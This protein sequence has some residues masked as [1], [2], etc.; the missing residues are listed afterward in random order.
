MQSSSQE[1]EQLRASSLDHH[2]SLLPKTE[3]LS[4]APSHVA[5][6]SPV[7]HE[8]TPYR[9]SSPGWSLI[10]WKF[11]I[12]SWIGSLCFFIAILVVLNVL[13]GRPLPDL[14]Y[15]ITPNAIIGLL[16]TFGQALLLMPVSSALGQMKWLQALEKRPMDNFETLDKASRGPLGSTKLIVGRKSGLWTYTTI[17]LHTDAAYVPIAQ[18]MNGTGWAPIGDTGVIEDG[19]D[20]ELL[21]APYLAFFNPLHTNFTAASIARCGSNNCT[22]DSYQT[23][24]LRS[25]CHDLSSSLNMTKVYMAPYDGDPFT[26]NTD[27]YTLPNGFGLT[28]AQPRPLENQVFYNILNGMVNVTTSFSAT[29]LSTVSPVWGSIAFPHNGSA[30]MSVFVVGPS[31]GTI[32]I[33]PD[34]NYSKPMNGSMFAPPVA[35]ECLLQFC[36]RNMRAEVMN[37]TIYETELFTWT[38][39]TIPEFDPTYGHTDIIF[40]SHDSST[41]F[42]VKSLAVG[43]GGGG[44]VTLHP[45]TNAPEGWRLDT[46]SGY[47][48]TLMQRLYK[49]MNGSATG[50]PDMMDNLV[51]SISLNMRQISYQPPPVRGLAFTATSHAVVTWEWLILPFFELAGSLV[52]LIIVIIQKRQGGLPVPWTNSTLAYFFHG[53]DE[54]PVRGVVHQSEEKM[55]EELEV[56]FERDDDGGHLV[57]VK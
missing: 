56:R 13:N 47:S 15:G 14:Q 30:L 39:Q 32:P 11:E 22:W 46:V 34:M 51:N 29:S 26:Y 1:L 31:P 37:G 53:L 45:Y 18:F 5:S 10:S 25:T 27:H 55:A 28:G 43:G 9:P 42:V 4:S 41:P 35:F 24:G 38:N 54:R 50:F 52:F 23:L 19:V 33:Q 49:A 3:D 57:I 17:Y 2:Q 40:Q 44:N 36:V 48:S 20:T 12:L 21:N 16:A 7:D 6:N 8:T